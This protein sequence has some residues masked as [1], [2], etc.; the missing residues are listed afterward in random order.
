MLPIIYGNISRKRF[1]MI[2]RIA[3]G[4][5]QILKP[6]MKRLAKEASMDAKI[7]YMK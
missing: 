4:L 1:Y 7:L 3:T 2:L 5:K 6:A